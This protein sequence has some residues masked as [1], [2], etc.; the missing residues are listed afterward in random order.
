MNAQI[1]SINDQIK[2]SYLVSPLDATILVKYLNANEI[3]SYGKPILKIA[4]MSQLILRVYISGDQLGMCKLGDDV[5]V[6]VLEGQNDIELK[7]NI[8]WISSKAEFTPKIIQ[9][10]NEQSN[11]V[12]A[13]KVIVPNN[14]KLKIGMPGEIKFKIN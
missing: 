9:T 8:S 11:L 10:K 7:G 2:K 3:V 14:G 6:I 1:E 4:N 13:V 5:A 12:Y